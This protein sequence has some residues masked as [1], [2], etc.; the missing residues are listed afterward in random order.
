MLSSARMELEYDPADGELVKS[1]LR[2]RP[3]EPEKELM[4][5]ILE[6][7]IDDFRRY[8]FAKRRKGRLLY[9]QARDWIMESD[10]DWFLSFDSICETLGINPSCL[11]EALLKQQCIEPRAA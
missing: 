1:M 10:P 7:A 9:E 5:A 3:R 2:A 11:R 8:A 4:F 6:T